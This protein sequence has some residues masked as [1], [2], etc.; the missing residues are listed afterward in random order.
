MSLYPRHFQEPGVSYFLFGP[1]GTGKTTLIRQLH[2]DALW[3]DLLLPD[4]E[5]SLLARP[6]MLLDMIAAEP[7]KKTVVIDEVQK[8]PA[9]LNIVHLMIEKKEGYQ[10]VLTGSSS[11]KLKRTGGNLLGG[12]AYKRTLHPFMA[13]ELGKD[14]DLEKALSRGMLPLLVDSSDPRSVLEGYISLYLKEEIQTEGLI[15]SLEQFIRFL[16]VISFSHGS[17]LNVLNVARESEIKRSTVSNYV[18]ILEELLLAYQVPVFTKR[19]T[20][21][22]TSHP[23]FYLFDSGVFQVLRS[24]GPL[25]RS[26]EIDGVAL[27]GLVAQHLTAWCDYSRKQTALYFWRTRSDLEVDFVIYGEDCFYAIEV[28]SSK[29]IAPSDLKGLHAFLQDYPEAKALFLYRGKEKLKMGE[30]LCLP[31]EEFLRTLTP[32]QPLLPTF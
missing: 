6:E 18:D 19:A 23:K 12:R 28:K 27:E 22:L 11:R 20:R 4:L 13:S 15:R 32:N 17:I 24:K 26:Q 14:F 3:L 7:G 25:D 10:F 1:R 9:L 2:P 8:V 29:K 31:V 5:R 30:V 21:I 16:D